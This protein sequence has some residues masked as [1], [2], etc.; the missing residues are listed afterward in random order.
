[1]AVRLPEV[2]GGTRSASIESVP[3]R[4]W[5]RLPW[6]LVVATVVVG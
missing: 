2:R 3:R 5:H 6:L 4:L 1:M